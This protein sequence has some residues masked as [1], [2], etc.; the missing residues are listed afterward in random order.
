MTKQSDKSGQRRQNSKQ[1][2]RKSGR[3]VPA[4]RVTST[5]IRVPSAATLFRFGV[6]DP[7]TTGLVNKATSLLK[8]AL[9]ARDGEAVRKIQRAKTVEEV[10]DLVTLASGLGE[11]AWQK[12]MRQ[13]GPA[14][15]PIIS[16]RL[17]MAKGIRDQDARDMTFEK[18]IGAL[19]WRGD[20]GAGVLLERF[21]DLNDYGQSL[22]C[23]MLGLLGE[24]EGADRIW[25]FYQGA[26]RNRRESHFVG[27]LWGLID[28]KDERAG[29][30]LA[31]MLGKKQFF[32]ELFGFLSLAGDA[33][34][35]LPLLDEIERRP[36]ER[37][38]APLMALIGVAHRIGRETLLTEF[39][40]DAS[41]HEPEE[42]REL[43][44]DEL[45]AKGDTEGARQVLQGILDRYPEAQQIR[46]R[47]RSLR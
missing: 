35:V 46:E 22:A 9:W 2:K 37:K 39:E 5:E 3:R 20:A 10:V 41:P 32:Y 27:A 15:V 18:L 26:V 29:K 14:V 8:P 43:L 44:A 33:R 4:Q 16:E 23:V 17:Q 47:I 13:L 7:T 30:A 34:A 38:A 19:R 11:P 28:L 31:D 40:K 25:H 21:G 45:L 36:D 12:R 1:A 24:Q 42:E 6:L